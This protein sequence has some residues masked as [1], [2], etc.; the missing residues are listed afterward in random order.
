VGRR[1]AAGAGDDDD[2]L[3]ATDSSAAA[4][5]AADGTTGTA[6]AAAAAALQRAKTKALKKLSLQHL[7]GHVLPV[8][9]A[10][11]KVLGTCPSTAAIC[12]WYTRP[13]PR[14]FMVPS[15]LAPFV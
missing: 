3:D 4:A 10:L 14:Q 9:S 5:A 7:V 12:V 13:G 8:V 2:D 11:K 6:G 1:A 15:H